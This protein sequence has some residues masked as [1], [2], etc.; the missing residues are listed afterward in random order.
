MADEME[1]WMR[2]VDA[3]RRAAA[4]SNMD[5][6]K[7]AI[8]IDGGDG[9]KFEFALRNSPT[10]F[11]IDHMHEPGGPIRSEADGHIRW[12]KLMDV[13]IWWKVP[14]VWKRSDGETFTTY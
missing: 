4:Y 13:K 6:R 9:I 12:F 3:L 14:K 1:H 7:L 8:Q 5:L 11:T 2:A 10:V